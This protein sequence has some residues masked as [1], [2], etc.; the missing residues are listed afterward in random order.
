MDY[1]LPEDVDYYV[2]EEEFA[3]DFISPMSDFFFKNF[4]ANGKDSKENLLVLLNAI[5]HEQLGFEK[6][7]DLTMNPTEDKAENHGRKTTFYDIH[8][9]TVSGKKLIVEM[10]NKWEDNFRNRIFFYGV[11]AVMQQ[12]MRGKTRRGAWDFSLVP[13]ITIALCNFHLPGFSKKPLAYFNLRDMY[14]NKVYG[15]QLQ[16][17][18]VHMTEFT[19]DPDKCKTELEKIVFSM[20]NMKTIQR[21]KEIPFS[22]E[23]GDFYSR[24]ALRSRL[25][26]L[27]PEEREYYDRWFK[28][29]YDRYLREEKMKAKAEAEGTAKGLAKGLEEGRAKGLEEGRAEGLAKGKIQQAWETAKILYKENIPLELISSSTGLDLDELKRELK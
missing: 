1:E 17:V 23:E 29:E 11:E 10:Q 14:T 5:L 2:N 21:M 7:T 18:Y 27:E 3:Y 25:S 24:M 8:C 28:H 26:A 15:D 9:T 19:N 13:V 20:K 6:I 16:L 12:D 4:F 22:T